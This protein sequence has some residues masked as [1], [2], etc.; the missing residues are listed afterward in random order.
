MKCFI[1]IGI[2][3]TL[4]EI[5]PEDNISED[6]YLFP[7]LNYKYGYENYIE[8]EIFIGGYSNIDKNKKKQAYYAFGKILG[9]ENKNRNFIHNLE[10][11]E[12][13]SGSPLININYQIIG[14]YYISNNQKNYGIFIG[15]IIEKLYSEENK[16]NFKA[17]EVIQITT[18]KKDEINNKEKEIKTTSE[19]EEEKNNKKLNIN[20][21]NKTNNKNTENL[22][23]NGDKILN[24]LE[25]TNDNEKI[26]DKKKKS[27]I[28]K[29]DEKI[30][31][32]EN[33]DKKMNVNSGIN[34][35]IPES[36]KKRMED[37]EKNNEIIKSNEE[38]NFA[39]FGALWADKTFQDIWIDIMKIPNLFENIKNNPEYNKELEENPILKEGLKNEEFIKDIFT[40]HERLDFLSQ[41][42]SSLSIL[43]PKNNKNKEEENDEIKNNENEIKNKKI[44]DKMND[45]DIN[46][47]IINHEKFL[48]LKNMGFKNDELIKSALILCK[49]NIEEAKEYII[50]AEH[51]MKNEK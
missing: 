12:G 23:N 20:E 21:K 3:V 34:D 49:G 39:K 30:N 22:N 16:I 48:K 14:I 19:L 10:K 17:K 24:E 36:L 43:D 50:S 38:F 5:I 33:E 11:I 32:N 4:I 31:K 26:N 8:K 27:N 45:E 2:D 41:L 29:K 35:L 46:N 1:D 44:N 13:L 28:I 25:I 7:D 40:S 15:V 37:F 18:Y 47:S 9:V 42:F 51:N 6:K